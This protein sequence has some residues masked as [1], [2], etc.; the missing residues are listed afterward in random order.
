MD[1]ISVSSSSEE[2]TVVGRSCWRNYCYYYWH[3]QTI[4]GNL[5]PAQSYTTV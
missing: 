5:E 2:E 4:A 3:R 1:T